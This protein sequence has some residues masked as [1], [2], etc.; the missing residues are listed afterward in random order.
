MMM[1]GRRRRKKVQISLSSADEIEEP[2]QEI[3]RK[4]KLPVSKTIP[5]KKKNRGVNSSLVEGGKKGR[6]SLALGSSI[7]SGNNS[8]DDFM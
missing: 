7:I 8:D 4:V 1:S 3:L 2:E 5:R 6:L